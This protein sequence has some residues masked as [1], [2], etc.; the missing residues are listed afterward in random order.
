MSS[1]FS[2]RETSSLSKNQLAFLWLISYLGVPIPLRWR[3]W[4]S[5]ITRWQLTTLQVREETVP[6]KHQIA[7][8]LWLSWHYKPLL[9]G[10]TVFQILDRLDK[11]WKNSYS[12][13]PSVALKN[14][15]CWFIII[16]CLKGCIFPFKIP[17]NIEKPD[18][19]SI[20]IL[21]IILGHRIRTWWLKEALAIICLQ[22]DTPYPLSVFST[23]LCCDTVSVPDSCDIEEEYPISWGLCKD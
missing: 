2:S 14:C 10:K 19:N 11:F 9:E 8:K 22:W 20:Q 3:G 18:Y 16:Q 6:F 1:H 12:C 7:L 5:A 4:N 21:F 15:K 17:V 23:I 13:F